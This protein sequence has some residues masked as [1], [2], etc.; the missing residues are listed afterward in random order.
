MGPGRTTV[1]GARKYTICENIVLATTVLP[2]C[3]LYETHN[4]DVWKMRVYCGDVPLAIP[5]APQCV[6]DGVVALDG[7]AYPTIVVHARSFSL[8]IH[9]VVVAG[10]AVGCSRCASGPYFPNLQSQSR[11]VVQLWCRSRS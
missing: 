10:L 7:W 8:A 5:V 3:V 6:P 9:L 1:A 11:A 4:C 2:T